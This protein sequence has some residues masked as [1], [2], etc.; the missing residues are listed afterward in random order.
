MGSLLKNKFKVIRYVNYKKR[1]FFG[2]CKNIR[3]KGN[4]KPRKSKNSN[5]QIWKSNRKTR[6]RKNKSDKKARR[7]RN[8]N[9]L[10]KE[11]IIKK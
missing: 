11:V 9:K 1:N 5:R 6:N 2:I 8:N 7:A 4:R 10:E 3:P